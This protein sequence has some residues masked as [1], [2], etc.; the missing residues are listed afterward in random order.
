MPF[1]VR[2]KAV[3]PEVQ[4][5]GCA[6]CGSKEYIL[7]HYTWRGGVKVTHVVNK[8]EQL[9]APR[10]RDLSKEQD[11]TIEAFCS[12]GCLGLWQDKF[13]RIKGR[14]S[15]TKGLYGRF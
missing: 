14:A 11:F 6:Q 5:L 7:H 13:D 1:I 10:E 4:A 9:S 15:S 8:A 12:T 2:S 3:T